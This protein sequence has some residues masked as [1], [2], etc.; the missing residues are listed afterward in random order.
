MS[1]TNRVDSSASSETLLQ[2][3]ATEQ[4]EV[5]RFAFADQHGLVR[6]KSIMASAVPAALANGI[7][8]VSTNLLKDTADRTAWPVFNAQAGFEDPHLA[9]LSTFFQG[10]GDVRLIADPNTFKVLPWVTETKTGWVQCQAVFPDGTPVP[11][12]SR[13]V[14]QTALAQLAAR[15]LTYRVGLEV[16]FHILK[17][18]GAR[19]DLA[20]AGWPGT[21]PDVSL[22][23]TGYRLLAEQRSD[24]FEALFATLRKHLL[25]LGLPLISQEIELGPSQVEFVF[26]VMDGLAAADAMILLRNAVKQICRRAGYHA[27]FMCRPALPQVMSS[28]WHLHQSLVDQTGKNLFTPTLEDAA[29]APSGAALRHLSPLGAQFLAGL[30]AHAPGAT[31]F[32]TPT[33]NG[34]RRYRPNSLAPDTVSW[35]K[36]N[37]GAMLR[38]INNGPN[39]A[40]TRIENR[41]GEPAA[42]PY[43][44]LAAQIYSGLDGI[45]RQLTPPPSSDTPY[46]PYA[47]DRTTLPHSLEAAIAALRADST[48]CTAFGQPFITWLTHIKEA[49]IARFKAEVTAWEQREYFE[50]F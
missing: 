23:N 25:D 2:R 33:I 31:F 34:Y 22:V 35:A 43:L 27:T 38:V 47:G 46:T 24:S 48:L 39:D 19:L 21:P 12:D 26:D 14:L 40:A 15:G 7:G 9:Q 13:T 4:I 10:A 36:D 20:D 32:S 3:L 1:E 29:R 41:A 6:G 42:N 50:L 28:G 17:L 16:E 49:E 5:V 44:Y 37:R 30:L 8:F 45:T 18:E 11:F